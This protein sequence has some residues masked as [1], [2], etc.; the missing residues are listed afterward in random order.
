MTQNHILIGEEIA[1]VTPSDVSS[2]DF[3]ASNKAKPSLRLSNLPMGITSREIYLF[4]KALVV[5]N[6]F[7]PTLRNGRRSK[8]AI[9]TLN[10]IE[11]KQTLLEEGFTFGSHK[12]EISELATKACK[13]CYQ[14]GHYNT[15]CPKKQESSTNRFIQ[16]KNFEQMG[17]YYRKYQPQPIKKWNKQFTAMTNANS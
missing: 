3:I 6:A 14:I 7:I 10:S 13:Y 2:A 1:R 8:F 9:I 17:R 5:T 11:E 16:Q 15:E 12:V 4:M